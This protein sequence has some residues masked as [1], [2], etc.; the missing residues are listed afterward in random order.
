[1]KTITVNRALTSCRANQRD[2]VYDLT[3]LEAAMDKFADDRVS[4]NELSQYLWGNNQGP[5]PRC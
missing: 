3:T 2:G 1:M 5:E 4:N